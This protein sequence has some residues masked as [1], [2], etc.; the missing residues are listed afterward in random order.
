MLSLVLLNGLIDSFNP[1]AIGVLL[2][3]VSI[4]LTLGGSRRQLIYFGIFYLAAMYL[5]YFLIGLGILHVFHLFGVH[6]FFG[7]V[8]ALVVFI[9]GLFQLKEYFFPRLYI[10]I[11]SPFLSACRVPKWD[12]KI[13]I[14]SALGLGFFVGLCEFPC[15]GAIYLATVALLSAKETFLNGVLY[16]LLYNVMFIL[17]TAAIFA[18]STH[19]KMVNAIKSFQ[20]ATHTKVKLVMGVLMIV[21]SILLLIWLTKPLI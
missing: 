19:P 15:S 4:I 6:N 14:F 11:L 3:Y 5:T 17:P 8:A 21:M 7:W 2:L 9:I 16:L 20:A 10:P 12:R 18:V 1:C 13:T